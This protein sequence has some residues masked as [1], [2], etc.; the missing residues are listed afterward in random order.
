[1]PAAIFPGSYGDDFTVTGENC[2][3]FWAREQ[4]CY[5]RWSMLG[6]KK[7]PVKYEK[8]QWTMYMEFLNSASHRITWDLLHGLPDAQT[9]FSDQLIQG[10]WL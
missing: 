10:L 3:T 8:S 6:G 9:P 7:N 5:F 2:F 4:F 1:M